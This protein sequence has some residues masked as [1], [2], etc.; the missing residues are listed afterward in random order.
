MKPIEKIILGVMLYSTGCI[1]EQIRK[2]YHPTQIGPSQSGPEVMRSEGAM[3][4]D[5]FLVASAIQAYF[6]SEEHDTYLLR[7][8]LETLD[9]LSNLM[10][11]YLEGIKKIDWQDLEKTVREANKPLGYL[12]QK[13]TPRTGK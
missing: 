8:N 9:R 12:H 1:S 3:A 6:N 11:S 10:N 4:I 5:P 7:R 2:A 13:T